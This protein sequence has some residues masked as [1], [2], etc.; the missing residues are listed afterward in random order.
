MRPDPDAY[1]GLLIF[2]EEER[3]ERLGMLLYF[4]DSFVD[5]V[6]DHHRKN[7]TKDLVGHDSIVPRGPVN[8]CRIKITKF[9]IR[10]ASDPIFSGSISEASLSTA[11]ASMIFERNRRK[12]QRS[13]RTGA[14]GISRRKPSARVT[15]NDTKSP[16]GGSAT[17]PAYA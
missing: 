14:A 1:D 11:P 16:K 3:G 13:V 12:P 10:F 8:H 15:P 6:V 4:E 5:I 7:R 9:E 2:A 17:L